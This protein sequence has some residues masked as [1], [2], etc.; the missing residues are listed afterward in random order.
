[1]GGKTCDSR[2]FA[3]CDLIALL[4]AD[5]RLFPHNLQ[6]SLIEHTERSFVLAAGGNL[7]PVT[8]SML[9]SGPDQ[10]A[11]SAGN[12]ACRVVDS[13]VG[14]HAAHSCHALDSHGSPHNAAVPGLEVSRGDVLQHQLI[15]SLLC[16]QPLQFGGLLFQLLQPPCLVHLECPAQFVP[17]EV[18]QTGTRGAEDGAR[19]EA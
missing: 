18:R 12:V 11:V 15:Q 5:D 17:V 13:P 6:V 8:E 2:P 4:L 1:M 14:T 3:L 9:T 10:H 19:Q 16:H 7:V